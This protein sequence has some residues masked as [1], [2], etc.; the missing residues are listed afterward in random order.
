MKTHILQIEP[1]D[2]WRTAADRLPR[3]AGDRAVLV[4]PQ[5]QGPQPLEAALWLLRRQ[6]ERRNLG[7]AVASRRRDVVQAAKRSGIPAFAEA[8]AAGSAEWAGAEDKAADPLGE[9]PG[10]EVL[11][12][13]ATQRRRGPEQPKLTARLAWFALGVLA[14][15]LSATLLLGLRA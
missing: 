6:A 12:A 1:A 13:Q 7:L 4:W 9:R 5:R 15:L 2:T 14:F 10:A 11:R 3:S 8:Q